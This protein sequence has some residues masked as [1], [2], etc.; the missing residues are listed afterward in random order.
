[1]GKF[2]LNKLLYIYG[3]VGTGKTHL[4]QAAGNYISEH[5]P[6]AKALYISIE[7]FTNALI[8]AVRYDN[9]LGF[10]ERVLSY[11]VLLID[12]LQF[13]TGK[14]FTQAEFFK[15][16]SELLEKGKQVVIAC[17]RPPQDMTIMN[18]RF[19]SMFELG[20]AFEIRPPDLDT[21]IE[22]LRRRLAEENIKL[23]DEELR[24]I[25]E[26]TS[27]NVRELL[28]AYNRYVIYAKMTE[29]GQIHHLK[30]LK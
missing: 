19:T 25:A 10:R 11:D 22:I 23:S 18:E 7:A 28:N 21:R 2:F 27:D 30:E 15:T 8:D 26:K 3:E 12:D 16:V 24:A 13:I 5:H 29:E 6:A 9:S 17:T 14:E 1:L 4:I 20:G